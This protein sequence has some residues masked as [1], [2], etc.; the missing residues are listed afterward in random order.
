MVYLKGYSNNINI[1]NYDIGIICSKSEGFGRVT[2]EYMMNELPVIGTNTG[3]TP[4][5]ILDGE[6]GFLFELD[7]YE[8]LASKI[9][10]LLEDIDLRKK[11]GIAGRKRAENEFNES[12][13][14]QQIYEIWW[15]TKNS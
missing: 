4:E 7:D 5:I 1:Q 11:M 3:A 2:V 14:T 6:T 8:M 15:T 9:K 13:M 12:K 10:I